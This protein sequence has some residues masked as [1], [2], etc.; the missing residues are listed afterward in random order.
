MLQS[1]AAR[2]ALSEEF[3][4]QRTFSA[5]DLERYAGCP[6]RFFL[7]R[8]LKIE[9]LEDL[10]LEF[11]VLERG[12]VVHDVLSA[13][14]KAVNARL[15]RPGS[16]LQ[17]DAAEFQTLLDAAIRD[18]LPAE[19]RNPVRAAL[20]E[21]D[22]RLVV[23]WL[24]H[25]REQ[26]EKYDALW[27]DFSGP[28]AAELFEVSFGRSGEAPPSTDLPLEF[29]GEKETVRL[30]GRIDR[31]DTG[32]FAGRTIFN[33]IDYK[34]GRSIRLTP[35]SVAAGTTLQLPIY[36]IATMELIL[37]DRDPYPWRA[38]YWYLRDDGFKPRQAMKMYED[39]DGRIE[40]DPKWEDV[41]AGLRD[42]VLGLVRALRAGR[43]PVCSA[44]EHCTGHCPFRT[45]CRINQVRSLE[46][47]WQPTASE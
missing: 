19:P 22:R 32:V 38:G 20:R 46:K 21:V 15:G 2:S 30:S 14:H 26:I 43:F 47:T 39:I 35:E 5:T 1:A 7:E 13:F 28:M 29:V 42:T 9:P 10:S 18:S 23:E 37:N 6:F 41:R 40:L 25:Y 24:S 16:P 33:I 17:L 11:D 3:N 44:D 31:I 36:A 12:R 4:A 8:I 27:E 34:T 45:V